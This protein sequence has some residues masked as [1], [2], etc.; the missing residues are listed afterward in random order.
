[1]KQKLSSLGVMWFIVIIGSA[2]IFITAL[3][4]ILTDHAPVTKNLGEI[5]IM[6]TTVLNLGLVINSYRHNKNQ[7]FKDQENGTIK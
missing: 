3:I 5:L 2:L 1:M 6:I 4:L 7:L